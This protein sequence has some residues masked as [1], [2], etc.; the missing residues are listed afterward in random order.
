VDTIIDRGR[1]PRLQALASP[2]TTS[3]ITR[4]WMASHAIAACCGF[5]PP[6]WLAAI[7]YIEDTGRSDGALPEML[8]RDAMGNPPELQARLD[9][10]SRQVPEDLG[11]KKGDWVR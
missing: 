11:G 8:D 4:R 10:N 3:S 2:F 9:R 7:Q 5:L 1:G 6:R